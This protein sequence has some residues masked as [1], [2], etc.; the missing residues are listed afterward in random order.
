M[1]RTCRQLFLQTPE[2]QPRVG[3]LEP[4]RNLRAREGHAR[5]AH[6]RDL[7]IVAAISPGPS[8]FRNSQRF[9]DLHARARH[10]FALR[11]RLRGRSLDLHEIPRGAPI[12]RL[13][14][15]AHLAETVQRAAENR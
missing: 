13:D 1:C 3:I 7:R 2:R 8:G 5:R 14:Q 6:Q 12:F 15:L 4:E 11:H 9:A 10:R